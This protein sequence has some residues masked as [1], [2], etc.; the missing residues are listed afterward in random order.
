MPA[1]RDAMRT[2]TFAVI[3]VAVD[4]VG[5]IEVMALHPHSYSL[6]C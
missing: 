6:R 2:W 4:D 1:D 3:A 5:S